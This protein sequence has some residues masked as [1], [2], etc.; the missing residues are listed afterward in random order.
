MAILSGDA[1]SPRLLHR[2]PGP[3]QDPG[4]GPDRGP[5]IP[6]PVPR[7]LV[8]R[9][10]AVGDLR[11][12]WQHVSIVDLDLARIRSINFWL[13]G[14]LLACR[15]LRNFLIRESIDLTSRVDRLRCGQRQSSW[16]TTV[17]LLVESRD[18]F[19]ELC[20]PL[21]DVDRRE[22]WLLEVGFN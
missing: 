9:D 19:R 6:D 7:L 4:A 13:D 16:T 21:I 17:D 2:G 3:D 1:P 12:D 5:G 8:H 11:Q 22:F 10:P 20:D 18:P 15:L 14:Q